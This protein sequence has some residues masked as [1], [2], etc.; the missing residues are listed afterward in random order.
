[1]TY[2]ER[3]EAAT[4]RRLFV[5]IPIPPSVGIAIT[6][7]VDAIRAAGDPGVRDVRWVRLDGLHL[8]IRFVGPTDEERIADVASAVDETAH[9]LHPFDVVIS[10]GGAF[11]S[12]GRPR[13]L[14]LGVEDGAAE[15]AA[16]ATTLDQ[17]LAHRGWPSDERPHRAHLTLARSDGVR[18]GPAV[19]RRLIEAAASVRESFR[20]DSLV[21][22]ETISGG[23]PARYEPLHE[24]SIG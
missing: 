1:V 5:A 11:P 4:G 14:W 9:A 3:L 8:T 16:A 6:G 23:G 15:L 7:L 19:A 20:A 17:A 24:T 22:F 10:G 12:V 18:A 2:R 21:L 13:A